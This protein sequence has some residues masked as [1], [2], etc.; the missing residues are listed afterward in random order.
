MRLIVTRPRAQAADWLVRL[1]GQGVDA[2]ALPLIEIEGADAEVAR[3][4]WK[5][6]EGAALAVFVS[7]NAVEHGLAGR[8]AGAAWPSNVLA[9]TVGPASARALLDAGVPAELLVTPPADA[10][11][12]DSEVLWPLLS[13]RN[14]LGK[15][16][17]LLRGDGGR[18]WLA[19]QLRG[20]GAEVEAL[21]VYRRLPPRL[22]GI[23]AALLQEAFAAPRANVWLFSSAEAVDKL[24]QLAGSPPAGGRAIA[25]HA[26]RKE[27]AEAAGWGQVLLARPDA[28]S[29]AA[30]LQ[31]LAP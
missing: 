5:R 12:F 1:A 26:R 6:L 23:E 22:R 13:T 27:A 31:S 16:V 18:E 24:R 30:H 20:R 4:A 19:D 11:S 21:S 25:T 3:F 15:R 14:W 17:L 10:A 7:P 29:V 9:A 28:A 8:P 2:V